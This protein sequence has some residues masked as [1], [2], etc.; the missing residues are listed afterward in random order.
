[1]SE[2]KSIGRLYIYRSLLSA[3]QSHATTAVASLRVAFDTFLRICGSAINIQ[4]TP[5][6]ETADISKLVPKCSENVYGITTEF[7]NDVRRFVEALES[8]EN[9][10]EAAGISVE[11]VMADI[12]GLVINISAEFSKFLSKEL[13]EHLTNVKRDALRVY[14]QAII[15]LANLDEFIAKYDSVVENVKQAV[16]DKELETMENAL[17]TLKDLKRL[18]YKLDKMI[19]K[20][21][22]ELEKLYK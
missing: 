16:S 5:P 3:V 12:A 1:M 4:E 22:K 20:V 9:L 6:L 11:L 7:L 21:L 8:L 10:T 13:P 2:E 18:I 19:R 14:T 15:V 17:Q